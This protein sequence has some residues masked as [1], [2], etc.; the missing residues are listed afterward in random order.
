MEYIFDKEG[1]PLGVVQGAYIHDM[2]G[3]PVGQLKGE[4]VLKLT[5]TYVGELKDGMILDM[6]KGNFGNA[7]YAENPGKCM[8]PVAHAPRHPFMSICLCFLS[9]NCNLR[10]RRQRYA[11]Y[12]AYRRNAP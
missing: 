2:E 6:H 12:K 5:G 9:N 3:N 11:L 4:H 1:N 7:G 8:H 10:I